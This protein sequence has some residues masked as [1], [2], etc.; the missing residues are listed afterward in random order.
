MS[1]LLYGDIDGQEQ[2]V[3]NNT[4]V[5]T[6]MISAIYT[7]CN[8]R[9][10]GYCPVNTKKGIWYFTERYNSRGGGFLSAKVA[11]FTTSPL[12]TLLKTGFHNSAEFE[13]HSAAGTNRLSITGTKLPDRSH[14]LIIIK[15]MLDA[16]ATRQTVWLTFNNSGISDS[17]YIAMCLGYSRRLIS[18]LPS[19]LQP[20]IS[21]ACN[22]TTMNFNGFS[23]TLSYISP[24]YLEAMGQGAAQIRNRIINCDSPINGVPSVEEFVQFLAIIVAGATPAQ[25]EYYK[26]VIT[27]M[28]R[29]IKFD[30]IIRKPSDIAM[31]NTLFKFVQISLKKEPNP[32]NYLVLFSQLRNFESFDF[33]ADNLT[34][35][36]EQMYQKIRAAEAAKQ[37]TAPKP[38]Q[39]PVQQQQPPVQPIQPQSVQNSDNNNIP[40]KINSE[41]NDAIDLG[42]KYFKALEEQG[43]ILEKISLLKDRIGEIED[44][45]EALNNEQRHI[46]NEINQKNEQLR[47]QEFDIS[48]KR[49]RFVEK[50][51]DVIEKAKQTEELTGTPVTEPIIRELENNGFQRNWYD[52]YVQ[53]RNNQQSQTDRPTTSKRQYKTS[54]LPKPKLA[55]DP[56]LNNG[57]GYNA[58]NN[59]YGNNNSGY[60]FGNNNDFNYNAVFPQKNNSSSL[61]MD[62]VQPAPPD[63]NAELIK[64]CIYKLKKIVDHIT[65]SNEYALSVDTSVAKIDPTNRSFETAKNKS[66][67]YRIYGIFDYPTE[68]NEKLFRFDTKN[69]YQNFEYQF[70]YQLPRGGDTKKRNKYVKECSK[71]I[72]SQAEQL[73]LL[74]FIEELMKYTYNNDEYI[75]C[76][77]FQ[78]DEE[79][80]IRR[81][82]FLNIGSFALRFMMNEKISEVKNC[83]DDLNDYVN[84]QAENQIPM[85]L[86]FFSFVDYIAN[87]VTLSMAKKYSYDDREGIQSSLMDEFSEYH[88]YDK[89]ILAAH[90]ADFIDDIENYD[91]SYLDF[92]IS[93][94]TKFIF[95]KKFDDDRS[96]QLLPE[97]LKKLRKKRR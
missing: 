68:K 74:L 27:T 16:V 70:Y 54:S 67:I 33:Q 65:Q 17:N 75:T 25:N 48:D 96:D 86:A 61:M 23:S 32:R 57:Y 95:P 5:K 94:R 38:Q 9:M 76:A 88:L 14:A 44:E 2:P 73:T 84:E 82:Q 71:S 41:K 4:E 1:N 30:V 60:G 28:D 37:Q 26:K 85:K 6:E 34:K 18:V 39:A 97:L 19:R 35:Q 56:Q 11:D 91:E 36:L 47:V 7:A 89:I 49:N 13:Q 55:D 15:K 20:L 22:I 53:S 92:E 93:G 80:K 63:P 21:F 90:F 42:Q 78:K 3:F 24:K 81:S 29:Y 79:N 8:S 46:E 40:P 77:L 43:A 69:F 58:N 45:I 83:F 50:C 51:C 12:D 87:G 10:A 31:L 72:F 66:W 59:G 52:T 62:D 64:E